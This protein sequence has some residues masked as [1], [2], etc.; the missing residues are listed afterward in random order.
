MSNETYLFEKKDSDKMKKK[1]GKSMEL[2]I[3][4]RKET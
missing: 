3:L 4:A 1:L 2:Q